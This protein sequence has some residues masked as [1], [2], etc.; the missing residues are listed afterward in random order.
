MWNSIRT[1][2]REEE[3]EEELLLLVVVVKE[4]T[5]AP[6][7]V[8]GHYQY[9]LSRGRPCHAFQRGLLVQGPTLACTLV[10]TL[11]MARG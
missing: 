5:T 4:M 11:S 1:G 7:G 10:H 9:Y 8:V 6:V 2:T 3:E